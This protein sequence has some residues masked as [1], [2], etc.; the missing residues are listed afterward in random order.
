MT[1]GQA[2]PIYRRIARWALRLFFLP[3]GLGLLA[4]PFALLAL[5]QDYALIED[6]RAWL[7]AGISVEDD[8]NVPVVIGVT[9]TKKTRSL[10]STDRAGSWLGWDCSLSLA[11][12]GWRDVPKD[13]PFA[14]RSY[15]DGMAEWN[16]RLDAQLDA[17]KLRSRMPTGKRS[18]PTDRSSDDPAEL[19]ELR[20]LSPEDKA[21]GE[22]PRFGVVWGGGALLLR[23]LAW[24]ADSV[25]FL[26][27]GGGLVYASWKVSRR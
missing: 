5:K 7:G 24:L 18:L 15:D 9:C 11:P 25:L 8:A 19:P 23:W 13:D 20:L 2:E 12:V 1:T 26:G 3:L 6:T 22:P 14:G 21:V 4:L 10:R 17:L 16:R 27:I